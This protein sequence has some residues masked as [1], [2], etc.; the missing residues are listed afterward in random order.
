MRRKV[1]SVCRQAGLI[2]AYFFEN[3]SAELGMNLEGSS[4]LYCYSLRNS[5]Y[6]FLC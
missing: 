4:G 1:G 3:G 6:L 2:V 5:R